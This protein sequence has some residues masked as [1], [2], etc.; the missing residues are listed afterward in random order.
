MSVPGD[1]PNIRAVRA[2]EGR[3]LAVT[4]RGGAESLV[5]VSRPIADYAI[6]AP[7]RANDDRFRCVAVGE[8]GWCVRWSDEMEIS[9]DTLWRL[10]LEQGADWLKTWRQAHRMTQSEAAKALGV[11]PRMWRYYEAASHLLPKTVRLAAIG[12]DAQAH[13]A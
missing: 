6:F 11:S 12:L 8:W 5:D 7:L 13:A 2:D 10:A 9:A 4:W 1:V 3:S